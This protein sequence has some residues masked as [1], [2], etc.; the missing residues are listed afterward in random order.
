MTLPLALA[1]TLAF[2]IDGPPPDLAS[3]SECVD[4]LDV[5]I[6]NSPRRPHRGAPMRVMVTSESMPLDQAMVVAFRPDGT[7]IPLGNPTLTG[8]PPYGLVAMVDRPEVGAWRVALVSGSAILACQDI[9]VRERPSGPGSLEVGVDPFW[10]TRI[11]W[12]RDTENLFSLWVERLFDAPLSEDVSWNPLWKVIADPS[13]NL[14]YDHLGLGEDKKGLGLDPDCADFPYAM[15]AYFAWK[16]GLPF[17][18][19]QCRR[20]NA[21]RAPTCSDELTTNET[22]TDTA[23]R[24]AAFRSFY[25]KLK[26]TVHSSSLRGAPSDEDSDFYPVALNK[27]G[28]RPG[29]IYAD[30]YG[31]TMMVLRWYP[32]TDDKAG[33]LMT[34]DAQPDGTVGRRVFWKGA[35]LFPKDD[36]VAGAGW[37][38]FRPVRGRGTGLFEL[39]NAQISESIDY[40][41]FSTEQWERGQDGF[42]EAMDALISPAPMRPET[43]M[44]G[45]IDALHQQALRRVESIE[46]VRPWHDK[47]RG[48]TIPMPKGPDIFLTAGPWEDFSTPSRDMRMLIAIDTVLDFPAR[49]K[50]RPERFVFNPGETPDQLSGRLMERLVAETRARTLTYVR[51]DGVAQTLTLHDLLERKLAIEVAWNPNDCPEVRW[52]AP[53]GS[54]EMASCQRRAP[55]DQLER[56]AVVRQWFVDRQRPLQH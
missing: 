40:G 16:M 44:I 23:E 14:L 48:R 30:P 42:Y 45:T 11:K 18:M 46:A 49:V 38:R 3:L 43:A 56:M 13:R 21:E 4:T 7:T 32:Q 50:R 55:D 37:K 53:E 47:N 12:E 35:F 20:G 26:A 39:G 19:R 1:L 52:G 41:D 15:R 5:S 8:G 51:S 31:H 36:D 6:F 28:L 2:P 17:A 22:L 27:K 34:V 54:A 9:E 33:V 10:E 24:V 29:T 25:R